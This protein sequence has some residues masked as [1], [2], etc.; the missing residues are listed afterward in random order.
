MFAL[1]AALAVSGCSSSGSKP[2]SLPSISPSATSA[3]PSPTPTAAELAAATAVV[4]RYYMVL[5]DLHND[6]DA[7]AFAVLMTASCT[8]QQQ[9]QA[10]REAAA[11]RE[12]Y[13]DHV[14]L[15]SM[16]PTI[17]SATTADV[18]VQYDSTRAGLVDAQGN[19]ITSSPPKSGIKRV[20]HL[21]LMG[22]HWLIS[23]IDAA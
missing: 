21:Q 16:T 6:M 15:V 10:I 2:V 8:C 4:K 20:F 14:R 5:N 9:V 18:L 13:V 23:E 1:A 22:G 11:K 3:S 17:D 19:A 12:R 7:A